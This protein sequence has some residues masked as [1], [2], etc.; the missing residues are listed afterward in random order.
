MFLSFGLA[1][2]DSS[3]IAGDERFRFAVDASSQCYATLGQ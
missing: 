2:Q 3:S 1:E